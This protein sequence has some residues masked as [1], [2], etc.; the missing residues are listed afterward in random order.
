M[1]HMDT[2][3]TPSVQLGLE[4]VAAL[5]R[6]DQKRALELIARGADV[7]ARDDLLDSVLLY[8]GANGYDDV[9]AAAVAAGGDFTVTNRFG[10]ISIIPASEKG[11][12]STVRLLIELGSPVNHIN[13]LGWTALHEAIIL[14]DGGPTQ[15]QIVRLLL[16]GGADPRL[17]DGEG[18]T[19][20][21]LALRHGYTAIVSILD[22]YL[23][24]A[25]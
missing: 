10:G 25:T 6:G 21:D 2:P 14:S 19:P 17:P 18:T 20:R 22:E 7:N 3:A 5:R 15:Q 4:A 1:K 12:A 8:A 9:V 13:N 24:T 16:D 11:H 23:V